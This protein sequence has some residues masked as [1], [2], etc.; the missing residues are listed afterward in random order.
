MN[1]PLI[2]A[3]V[4][5]AGGV[6]KAFANAEAIGAEAIQIFGASPQSW[7]FK[8]PDKETVIKFKTAWE[9]SKVKSVFL[10]AA[11][12]V[13]LASPD[14]SARKK[15]VINLS[16]HLAIAQAL[17]ANGLIFH[18]GSGK[19]DMSKEEALKLAAKEMKEVLKNVPGATE[20]IIE[21]AAGGGDKVGA[22]A[23]SVGALIR[24]IK[25]LPPSGRASPTL[26]GR[27][28]VCIDTAHAFEAGIIERYEPKELKKFLDEWENHV[29]LKNVVAL[30][31]NDSKTA[32]NSRHDRHENIGE[33]FIGLKGFKNLAKEKSLWDKAWLL[34]VPGF[35]NNGP[36]KKNIDILKSC[37]I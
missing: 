19:G 16:G 1:Y 21:N 33:G 11:Y 20:L 22:T 31:V 13:N 6:W 27:V 9:K 14:A 15:S 8:L 17:G 37:F 35:D 4:S 10:H 5:V 12:L 7:A 3:H 34:E 28:K 32:F 24:L 36:D 18:V 26:G 23:E 29:G 30:H 2:G 25:S